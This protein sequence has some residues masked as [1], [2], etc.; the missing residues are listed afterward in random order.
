[1]RKC[2]SL[3]F[4]SLLLW[5]GCGQNSGVNPMNVTDGGANF[6]NDSGVLIPIMKVASGSNS[7]DISIVHSW[8]N[9]FG[10]ITLTF[11]GN[12]TYS[13]IYDDGNYHFTENGTYSISGIFV[14]ATDPDGYSYTET[15]T[16]NGNMLT[17]IDE[18]GYS[19]S[20]SGI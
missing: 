3:L 15:F 7:S 8:A 5:I 10:D 19:H 17:L 12:G 14:N 11:S 1:M 6:N 9:E 16:V 20:F 2:F 13:Y 18:Y 4:L